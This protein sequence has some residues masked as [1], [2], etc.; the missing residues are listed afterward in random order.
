MAHKANVDFYLYTAFDNTSAD[1]YAALEF[2]LGTGIN[3]RHLHYVAGAQ[4]PTVLAN[5]GSWFPEQTVNFP[6]VVYT[7]QYEIED[8]EPR[9]DRLVT[10]L[11]E[12]NSTNWAE[13][14][15]FIG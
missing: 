14:A 13:L 8:P 6:M 1:C 2:M 7:E 3:F 4:I 15:S 5:V 11:H 12:I 10:G 9:V